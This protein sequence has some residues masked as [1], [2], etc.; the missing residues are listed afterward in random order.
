[1]TA[2]PVRQT[3][4]PEPLHCGLDDPAHPDVG[5]NKGPLEEPVLDID[6]IQGNI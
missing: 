3:P 5:P 1:M 4:F 2:Q 6:Q